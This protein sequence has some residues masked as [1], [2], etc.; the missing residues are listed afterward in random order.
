MKDDFDYGTQTKTTYTR[1]STAT[2]WFV[3][4]IVALTL[5]GIGYLVFAA[6]YDGS[7]PT[8]KTEPISGAPLSN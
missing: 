7:L 2:G 5:L 8:A 1:E 3:G 6:Q 4:V